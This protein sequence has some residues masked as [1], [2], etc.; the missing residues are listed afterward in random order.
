MI[1]G[2]GEGDGGKGGGEGRGGGRKKRRRKGKEG[3]KLRSN[4]CC[5]QAI[6]SLHFADKFDNDLRG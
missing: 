2:G 3:G 4:L 5:S 1:A 6:E